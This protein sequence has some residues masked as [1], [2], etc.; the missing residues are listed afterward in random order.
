[1][2]L[3]KGPIQTNSEYTP[4]PL[5]TVKRFFLLG[6]KYDKLKEML[7]SKGFCTSPQPIVAA[8]EK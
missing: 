4:S 2:P 7:K 1:M 5:K 3:F 8:H 6:N